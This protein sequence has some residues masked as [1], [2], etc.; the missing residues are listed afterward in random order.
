MVFSG[1]WLV[2][3]L[4]MFW[5]LGG[6]IVGDFWGAVLELLLISSVLG[7]GLCVATVGYILFC[8]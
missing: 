4:V 8:C 3:G 1:M 6:W 2:F 7:I 5:L